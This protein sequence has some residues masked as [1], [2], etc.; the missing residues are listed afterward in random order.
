MYTSEA[1]KLIPDGSLD[2]VY[3][4]ARH[5]YC[6]CMQDL[7]MYWPKLRPGGLLAGHDYVYASDAAAM[8]VGDWSLCT[9]GTVHPGSVRAAVED[10]VKMRP[11]LHVVPTLKE[12]FPSY[13]IMKPAC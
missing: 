6:G 3:V 7:E 2:F 10:F 1:A 4:D 8:G 9:N 11:G 5:D 12:P 13:M